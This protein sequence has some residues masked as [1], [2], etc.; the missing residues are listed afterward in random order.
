MKSNQATRGADPK[1]T[2]KQKAMWEIMI[3]AVF[4]IVIVY[5]S[6]NIG[7][8]I[9]GT[10]ANSLNTSLTI[11]PGGHVPTI[12]DKIVNDTKKTI[13]N[14]SAGYTVNMNMVNIAAQIGIITLPLITVMYIR[15]VAT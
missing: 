12:G 3:A 11:A 10:I 13:G 14:L 4:A 8:F 6:A 2:W 5:A 7:A 15:R 1:P 9:N